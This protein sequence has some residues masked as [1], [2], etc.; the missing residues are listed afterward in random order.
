MIKAIIIDD[1]HYGCQA[2]KVA[3]E[4]YCLDVDVV[5][6]CEDPELGIEAIQNHKPD[7]VFLDVQMPNMSGFDVLKQLAP[8]N[9]EVIFVSSY[10]QYAIKAIKF[11]ALDYLL[12]PVD[13]DDLIQAVKKAQERMQNA[14]QDYRYQSIINNIQHQSGKIE[15]LAVP[16]MEGI[17]FFN[18]S[19]IIYCQADRNY[20]NLYLTNHQKHLISKNLKDFENLL[21]SSGFCRVHNSSLINMNHV[22]KYIKGEGGY[23]LLTDNHHVDIA[24][25]RKESFLNLLDKI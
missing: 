25:R 4:Q 12:K 15:K 8:I 7:L 5:A 22:K 14:G 16:T 2:L 9:F 13:V 18:I 1:E 3:L 10:D 21:S 17:E 23:V 20:T 11:S 19:D 24:R 6:I